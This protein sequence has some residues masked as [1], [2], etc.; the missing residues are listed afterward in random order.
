[1]HVIDEACVL[2]HLL[3]LGQVHRG[4]DVMHTALHFEGFHLP[5][6]PTC[7][8]ELEITRP[9]NLFG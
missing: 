9:V 2:M 5:S 6:F 3:F 7:L 8:L 1:M 4:G